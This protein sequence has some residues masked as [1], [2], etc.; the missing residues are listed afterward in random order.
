M[1]SFVIPAH[2]EEYLLSDTLSQLM[3]A[4]NTVGQPSEVIVVDD[5]STDQTAAV[6]RAAGAQVIR[7]N[8]RKIAAV[9]NAGA[10]R[11]HGDRLV[12]LDADT[13]LPAGTLKAAL[14][15]LERG[16]IGGGAQVRV[17]EPI[18]LAAR[19]ILSL[20]NVVSRVTCW[21]PGCF[22]F[23]HRDAFEA[24]GGFD[25]Q[26]YVTEEL[27]LSQALKKLGRFVILKEPVNTSGRKVRLYTTP[28]LAG[29]AF[30]ILL[31]GPRGFR[32]NKGLDL[33]YDGRREGPSP[34]ERRPPFDPSR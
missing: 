10:Q 15:A 1:I 13:R 12:F 16:A 7:Q 23:M 4:I 26:Y 11:A 30:R 20:W 31:S 9:R 19:G 21:A 27:F 28:Q 32:C 24:V 33:W 25:E 2:N 17:M 8:L 29:R 5:A 22:M 34:L 14:T 18:G 6:G 3:A